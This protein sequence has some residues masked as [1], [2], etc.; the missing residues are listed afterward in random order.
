MKTGA[1]REQGRKTR[2]LHYIFLYTLADI[3]ENNAGGCS[4]SF[5]TKKQDKTI[6]T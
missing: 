5:F 6:S 4:G 2:S 1:R 3:K